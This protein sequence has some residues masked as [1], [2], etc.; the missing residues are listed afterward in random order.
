M[1]RARRPS[2][3]GTCRNVGTSYSPRSLADIPSQHCICICPGSG[4]APRPANAIN[5]GPDV[6]SSYKFLHLDGA[7]TSAG[8]PLTAAGKRARIRPRAEP[9]LRPEHVGR[10]RLRHAIALA[11]DVS[12][13]RRTRRY[14]HP[15]AGLFL[16]AHPTPTPGGGPPM[17]RHDRHTTKPTKAAR[18]RAALLRAERPEPVT[19]PPSARRRLQSDLPTAPARPLPMVGERVALPCM[20][21]GT[22]TELGRWCQPCFDSRSETREP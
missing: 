8:R 15:T 12:H 18:R 9:P 5:S 13:T 4:V 3:V 19:R 14:R 2:G 7:P 6:G 21:C 11:L 16:R 1:T 22:P 17:P 10:A 20:G